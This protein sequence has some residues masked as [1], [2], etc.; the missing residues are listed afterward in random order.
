METKHVAINI[1][2]RYV[3]FYWAE[4]QGKLMKITK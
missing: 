2:G 4:A 1:I 3:N